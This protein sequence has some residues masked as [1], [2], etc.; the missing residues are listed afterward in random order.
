M[1]GVDF[2]VP[3]RSSL[4]KSTSN[5]A[6]CLGVQH[7][8]KYSMH[9]LKKKLHWTISKGRPLPEIMFICHSECEKIKTKKKALRAFLLNLGPIRKKLTKH[10]KGYFL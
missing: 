3:K 5:R 10:Y 2:P 4:L 7:H 1:L 8:S 9:C 6:C